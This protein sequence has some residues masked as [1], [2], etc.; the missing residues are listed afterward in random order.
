MVKGPG[1]VDAVLM[2]QSKIRRFTV[3]RFR[4]GRSQPR[5]ALVRALAAG[6]EPWENDD[7]LAC[8]SWLV[9]RRGRRRLA[10]TADAYVT[11]ANHGWPVG[12]L[13]RLR[14]DIVRQ[15]RNLFHAV[16]AQLRAPHPSGLRGLAMT[17]SLL[18]DPDS[19]LFAR[20][21]DAREVRELVLDCLAALC[22]L[23]QPVTH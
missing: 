13:R 20:D 23:P 8:A 9:S 16:S 1:A 4:A 2:P 17:D 14:F 5:L 7:M 11:V 15:N 22:S 3:E 6:G 21:A 19:P 10:E 18:H 12:R